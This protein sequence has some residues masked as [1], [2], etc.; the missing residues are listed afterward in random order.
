MTA[1]IRLRSAVLAAG[2][3]GGLLLVIVGIPLAL[4]LAVGWPLH[5]VDELRDAVAGGYVPDD[6]VVAVLTAALW[7]LWAEF[8]AITLVEVV[9]VC[10]GRSAPRL[11]LA[12]GVQPLVAR[13]VATVVLVGVVAGPR[14]A[15]AEPR[16]LPTPAV[17]DVAGMPRPVELI[18]SVEATAPAERAHPTYVVQPQDDLWSIAERHLGDPFRWREIWELNGRRPVPPIGDVFDDENLIRPGWVLALPYDAIGVTTPPAAPTTAT[19]EPAPAPGPAATAEPDVSTP[20]TAAPAAEPGHGVGDRTDASHTEDDG[21]HDRPSALPCVA[22][23]PAMLVAGYV[24]RR[25]DLLRRAQLR[26]RRPGR[27]LPFPS[28]AA[29]AAEHRLRSIAA[30]EAVDWIDATT[31]LLTP[32]LRAI[33]LGTRPGVVALRAGYFGIEVLLD[34]PCAAPDGF[35]AADDGHT[36]RVDPA[37]TLEG[38]RQRAEQHPPA[39]PALATVGT[40]QEG[41]VLVNLEHLRA[42]RVEGDERRVAQFLTG[43][44][45]ELSAAPWARDVEAADLDGDGLAVRA[46]RSAQ[47]LGGRSA[48]DARVEESSDGWAPTVGIGAATDAATIDAATRG[49]CVVVVHAGDV[50]TPHR[51]V[52]DA[53][54]DARLEPVGLRVNAAG[55]DEATA[56]AAAELLAVA[57]AEDQPAIDEP[58]NEEHAPPAGDGVVIDLTDAPTPS[59]RVRVL[60]PVQVDGWETPPQRPKAAEL[61]AYVAC[62]DRPVPADRLRTALWADE[63]SDATF[64]SAVSRSRRWLGTDATGEDHLR[65]AHDGMY[66]LGPEV[67]CDWQDFRHFVAA[68]RSAAPADAMA[69][70]RDALTLVVDEPFA[71]VQPNTYTWAWSEQ[72]VSA[73][74]V[75]VTDAAAALGKLALEQQDPAIAMWA[76]NQGLRACPGNE[77]LYQLRMAASAQAGDFDGVDQ[78]Y[79][80]AVRAA[81]ALDPLDDVAPATRQLH[82]QL[83]ARRQAEASD[84]AGART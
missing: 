81:R 15:A 76:A 23:L 7:L 49:G 84:V 69:L 65:I 36:W 9:A 19:P 80:E 27:R 26:R 51:F 48:V 1:R 34:G 78:A 28:P 30:D 44:R 11:P 79:R 54:G 73:I 67:A 74:E 2:A 72:I 40:S 5:G 46:E 60:G 33:D 4:I 13:L 50:P 75:A 32:A 43:L 62:H 55:L 18:A 66:R 59:V 3:A 29:T 38:L 25:L 71:D 37:L 82:E 58:A 6:L 63:V 20:P 21:E 41:P 61:V 35:V 42:L 52:I 57:E 31:R 56:D 12:R 77:A 39:V 70:Y 83:R 22:L 68:A 14:A 64:R 8:T 10:R 17:A 45:V 16:P 53:D 47:E 24:V